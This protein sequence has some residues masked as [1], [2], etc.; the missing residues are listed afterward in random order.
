V[1]FDRDKAHSFRP[2]SVL[3]EDV[4]VRAR[5]DAAFGTTWT[6]RCSR[7]RSVRM[8]VAVMASLRGVEKTPQYFKPTP[9]TTLDL[10]STEFGVKSVG[11]V[12][13]VGWLYIDTPF[14]ALIIGL[15]NRRR[16]FEVIAAAW[17]A[18]RVTYFFASRTSSSIT[19]WN[20]KKYVAPER[21]TP[22][23]QPWM[24]RE[25][26]AAKRTIYARGLV[27]WRFAGVM[28]NYAVACVPA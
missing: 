26:V 19:V 23:L 17:S 15:R 7:S 20:V 16:C 13:E 25:L 24:G 9:P 12:G 27:C 5:V 8:I 1:E 14:T 4:T 2:V 11:G 10:G 28:L 21:Q 3:G 22:S 6:E 18:P